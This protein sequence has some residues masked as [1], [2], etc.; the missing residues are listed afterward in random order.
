M[1]DV[2]IKGLS[3]KVLIDSGSTRT[4]QGPVFESVLQKNLTP[5]NSVI[6]TDNSVEPVIGEVNTV[7]T[8]GKSRKCLPVCIVRSLN[9]DC[10]LGIDS[11]KL[12]GLKIDFGIVRFIIIT[13][14]FYHIRVQI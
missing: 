11:L 7:L 12:F 10:I 5:V 6:L 14:R 2:E 4:C 13:D 8:L 1:L 9:Y 3:V